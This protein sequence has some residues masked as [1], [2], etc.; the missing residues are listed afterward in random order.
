MT[1]Y[2][3]TFE[4]NHHRQ[5][6]ESPGLALADS[7][8]IR[9]GSV[10]LGA[11]DNT[12]IAPA[13]VAAEYQERIQR[14][15]VIVVNTADAGI[16]GSRMTT[17]RGMNG[18]WYIETP[19]GV[20]A[21]VANAPGDGSIVRQLVNGLPVECLQITGAAAAV[22]SDLTG[23]A[24]VRTC[25]Y[26]S[27]HAD[28]A[29]AV[30]SS[31]ITV[32]FFADSSIDTLPDVASVAERYLTQLRL[33]GGGT[34]T[35]AEFGNGSKITIPY[36][37]GAYTF[38]PPIIIAADIGI[39]NGQIPANPADYTA[40]R[41]KPHPR[42][43]LRASSQM[44]A[45]QHLY[46]KTTGNPTAITSDTAL[47]PVLAARRPTHSLWRIWVEGNTLDVI[48]AHPTNL[49]LRRPRDIWTSVLVPAIERQLPLEHF[50]MHLTAQAREFYSRGI[51]RDFHYIDAAACL[52]L[53]DGSLEALVQW[54]E[55]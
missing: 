41:F 10:A 26:V 45:A 5:K 37:C 52:D 17:D 6:S 39:G 27:R 28:N 49:D 31:A 14:A 40:A 11:G 8:A 7:V 18:F 30:Q 23:P 46:P 21:L 1:E 48:L 15:D 51:L 55:S 13:N 54:P 35:L 42:V 25:C 22:V 53:F 16:A 19:A 38:G 34:L 33:R 24:L 3:F 4:L 47:V 36:A 43:F 2:R 32:D 9:S 29:A 12:I 50:G 44:W 20:G